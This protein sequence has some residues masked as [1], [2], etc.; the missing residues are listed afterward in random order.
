MNSGR[1]TPDEMLKRVHE[2]EARARRGRLKIFFGAAPGVGKTFAML[3]SAQ[4][5]RREGGDVVIGWL[6]SH[7]RADTE[8]LA[9]GL[10]RLPPRR[11][12]HRGLLLQEFDLE[13]AL[14]RRPELLLVDELPHTNAP[15]SRHDRR[16][17]DVEELLSAGIHVATTLN[18]QH[19]ESLVDVVALLTG[20]V[21]QET[22]P[23]RIIDLA[24]EIELVDLPPED[25]LARLREGKI[26]IPDQASRAMENFFTPRNLTALRELVLRRTADRVGARREDAGA[27]GDTLMVVVTSAPESGNLIRAAYRM[28][29]RLRAHWI[30]L[31]VETPVFER[32]S[33]ADRE[34]LAGH[35]A[36]AQRLGAET[37]VV[38]GEKPS[39]EILNAAS[40]RR[41]TRVLVGTPPRRGWRDRLAGNLAEKLIRAGN[42]E[43]IAVPGRG[44]ES[45]AEPVRRP[46]TSA[47]Q[48]G[49]AAMVVLAVTVTLWL[50][51]SFLN[52][53]DQAMVYL[54]GVLLVSSTLNRGPSLMTALLSV[55]ALDCFFVPPFFTL[56]VA[57]IRYLLTFAVLL[58]TAMLVSRQT[59]MIREQAEA[60]RYRERR[61]VALYQMTREFA[62][63]VTPATIVNAVTRHIRQLLDRESMLLLDV[64]EESP[65]LTERDRAVARWVMEHG[66]PAGFGTKTLPGGSWLFLPV[67]S[68]VRLGVFGLRA[69]ETAGPLSP[70]DNQ[71]LEAAVGQVAAAL[72]RIRAGEAAEGL[73]VAIEIERTRNLMLSLVSH[74]LRTPLASMGGAAETLLAASD[75]IS[76]AD[77]Q[78]LLE[79]IRDESHRLGRMV[80]EL[81]DLSRI[82][83]GRLPLDRERFPLEELIHSAL[84][85][86]HGLLDSRE[87]RVD[88]PEEMIVVEAD[89]TLL[90]QVFVNLLENAAKYTPAGSPI[91]IRIRAVQSDAAAAGST[92]QVEVADRGPGIAPGEEREIFDKFHRG[93]SQGPPGTGLGL[94]LAMAILKV[95]GGSIRAANRPDGGAIFTVEL[96]PAA[97]PGDDAGMTV[98]A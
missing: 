41:A 12:E 20:V 62:A 27:R 98:R 7:G 13:A 17:Q 44:G 33:S 24:D 80:G 22:V 14:A 95:H 91:D 9:E 90:T 68:D 46:R 18:V 73:R 84:D 49:R 3:E 1:P 59:L 30:A 78:G 45:E 43:V 15:G 54:L 77:R 63:A 37:M 82:E 76:P 60:A 23:D 69:H 57:H 87:V 11:V 67:G 92:V 72:E 53:A 29:S 26:Y 70:A 52:L 58:V 35:L 47:S 81:L 34:R 66:Q 86:T 71:I 48:Y 38:R 94:A 83:S 4:A 10:P 5:R 16:W 74:D 40:Q 61:T 39:E 28:A 93:E 56:D 19:V 36:L 31:S 50:T 42:V 8:R 96:P 25:L 65:L 6:E 75:A 51:R 85:Q 89:G 97:P 64:A 2:E 32:L 88:Q 55:A 21:V 79:S